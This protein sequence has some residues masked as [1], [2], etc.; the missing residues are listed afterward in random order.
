MKLSEGYI[1]VSIIIP[2]YNK[3]DVL[4]ECIE[5]IIN[6]TYKN[7]EIILIDDGSTDNTKEL[8]KK[9]QVEDDRIVFVPKKNGGV[10]SARNC[11]LKIMTGDYVMFVDADDIVSINYVEKLLVEVKKSDYKIAICDYS[12]DNF[13]MLDKKSNYEMKEYT[14]ETFPITDGTINRSCVWGAIYH[15]EVVKE[16]RF[17]EDLCVGED[18]LFFFE[19]LAREKRL[20]FVPEILY[21]YQTNNNSATRKKYDEKSFTDIIAWKRIAELYEAEA[22][23]SK[24]IKGRVAMACYHG[25]KNTLL[26]NSDLKKKIL[27]SYREYCMYI[28]HTKYKCKV[29][30]MVIIT[31]FFPNILRLINKIK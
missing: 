29:K 7:I 14:M 28:L 13:E 19:C 2:I 10:S 4:R 26:D 30:I 17:E 1:K 20:L 11:G 16:L 15:K 27:E 6:Q 21:L 8:I 9:L 23:D 22:V 3:E 18:S 24:E 5:R 25:V 12:I 31:C